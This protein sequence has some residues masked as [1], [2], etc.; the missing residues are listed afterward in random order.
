MAKRFTDTDKWKKPW[1]RKLPPKMKLA[2]F[3]ICDNVDHAG[4]WP[5]DFDLMSYLLGE[6]VDPQDFRSYFEGRFEEIEPDKFW[7]PS[8][9]KFQYGSLN[10]NN[11]VHQSALSLLPDD[12][13]KVLTSPL[14]GAKDKDKDKYKDKDKEEG[15]M[16]GELLTEN[17]VY[18]T[19]EGVAAGRALVRETIAGMKRV[20]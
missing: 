3:Y 12:K 20:P 4:I 16:G 17:P 15:G 11:R 5:A 1:F 9:I 18:Q 2:W 7:F 14:Q 13:K 8:F 10:P 6:R 19:P